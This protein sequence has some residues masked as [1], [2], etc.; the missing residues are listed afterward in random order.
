[1]DGNKKD[2]YEGEEMLSFWDKSIRIQDNEL[3]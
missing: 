2:T 1:M 3:R